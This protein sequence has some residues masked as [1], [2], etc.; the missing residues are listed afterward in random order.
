M[1]TPDGDPKMKEEVIAVVS[2]PSVKLEAIPM[3]ASGAE[4]I[5]LYELQEFHAPDGNACA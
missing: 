1:A 5:A 4:V 2:K 3:K